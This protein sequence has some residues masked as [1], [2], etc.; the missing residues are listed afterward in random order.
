MSND[1]LKRIEDK[2]DIVLEQTYR[3]DERIKQNTKSI[4]K[5]WAAVTTAIT[6]IFT[7]LG[8]SFF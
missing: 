7:F 8:K 3:Q 2:L 1:R 5:L 4:K 6:G